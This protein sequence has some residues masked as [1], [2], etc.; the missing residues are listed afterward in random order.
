[1]PTYPRGTAQRFALTTLFH[2]SEPFT[3]VMYC[4]LMLGSRTK[5]GTVPPH[6]MIRGDVLWGTSLAIQ[7]GKG[8]NTL[9]SMDIKRRAQNRLSRF[10]TLYIRFASELTQLALHITQ[11]L[12]RFPTRRRLHRHCWHARPCPRYRRGDDLVPC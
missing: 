5:R 7:T 2:F 4:A 11:E 3:S 10:R 8:H 12:G 1:M 6:S 9:K